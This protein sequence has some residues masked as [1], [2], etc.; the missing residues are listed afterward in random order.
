VI[1]DKPDNDII[2]DMVLG[3]STLSSGEYNCIDTKKGTL[4]NKNTG[5]EIQCAPGKIIETSS[6]RMNIVP[7]DEKQVSSKQQKKVKDDSE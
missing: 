5:D 7:K 2:C 1:D 4:F 6:G 3:R